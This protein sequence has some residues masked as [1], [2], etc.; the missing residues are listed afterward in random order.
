MSPA[1][2]NTSFAPR[3]A[4]AA[5][6]TSAALAAQPPKAAKAGVRVINHK[7]KGAARTLRIKKKAFVKTGRP[8]APGERKALRKRI[9]LS[10]TNALEVPGLLKLTSETVKDAKN[11]GKVVEIP[12]EVVDQLRAVEAFKITQAWRLFRAPSILVREETV[13]L[14]KKMEEAAAKKETNITIL[15]GA[16][17]TGKSML[18][19]QAMATAFAKGW[20]VISIPEGTFKFLVH[21]PPVYRRRNGS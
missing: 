3:V 12:G 4:A 7:Q 15:N 10:N 8:P 19:L 20:V 17:N 13:N 18:L 1:L 21:R 16:R 6:T 5:F 14:A 11:I 9:V 2:S